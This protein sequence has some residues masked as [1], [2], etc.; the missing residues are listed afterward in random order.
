MAE[1][2]SDLQRHFP[3]AYPR[4]GRLVLEIFQKREI[5]GPVKHLF[6]ERAL[7]GDEM[8]DSSAVLTIIMW[9]PRSTSR[10]MVLLKAVMTRIS[11][12]TKTIRRFIRHYYWH[13][14]V[15]EIS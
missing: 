11:F 4:P 3:Y 10:I 13:G 12:N 9:C 6:H 1:T 8:M 7:I 14:I 2:Q 5:D 15:A